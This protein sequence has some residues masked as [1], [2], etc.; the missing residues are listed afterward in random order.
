[1]MKHLSILFLLSATLCQWAAAQTLDEFRA[2]VVGTL[3]AYVEG[4]ETALPVIELN[5]DDRVMVEFDCLTSRIL[6][7]E[8]S[9]VHCDRNGQPSDLQP[10]E[11]LS[12]FA[13]NAVTDYAPSSGTTVEYVNYRI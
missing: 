12:G 13:V 9:V 4:D 3:R 6:D 7:L 5:G 10:S 1:M 8:Y 2:P 11:Y